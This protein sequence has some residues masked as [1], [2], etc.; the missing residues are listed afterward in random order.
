ME[1]NMT[2]TW[3]YGTSWTNMTTISWTYETSWTNMT[4]MIT[5]WEEYTDTQTNQPEISNASTINGREVFISII[6]W[7]MCLFTAIGNALVIGVFIH[8]RRV[9]NKVSNLYILNLAVADFFVGCVSLPINYFYRQAGV[10]PFGEFGCKFWLLIDFTV[11]FE[12]VWAVVLISYDRYLL[13]TTGLEYDKYQT[14][15][16]FT[17]FASVTWSISFLRY[18]CM[19]VGYDIFNGKSFNYSVTCDNKVFSFLPY[20][21]CDWMVTFFIPVVLTFYFNVKLYADIKRRSRGLPRNW[22]SVTP[23]TARVAPAEDTHS[24]THSSSHTPSQ[25]QP[26][27]SSSHNSHQ[28]HT[29]QLQL[30][31]NQE[32]Q[33]EQNHQ[34]EVTEFNNNHH[35]QQLNV[36]PGQNSVNSPKHVVFSQQ[37]KPNQQQQQNNNSQQ[38]RPSSN[39]VPK[40]T[41]REGTADIRKHRRTAITLGLIVAVSASCWAPYYVYVFVNFA[42]KVEVGYQ[43]LTITY[44]IWWGNSTLNPLLYVA[45][46]PGIRNGIAKI[47]RIKK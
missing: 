6:L 26:H 38:Q 36:P 13:V 10:W 5:S 22:A 20:I 47:L 43:F 7:A 9:R 34:Q 44:Y 29:S 15:K 41:R 23:G 42:F 24:G 35:Q 30:L 39:A 3:A 11:C 14:R 4:T 12:S 18:F 37:S 40:R 31:R 8:D 19:F 21:I 1:L 25:E 2:T 45:T 17:K 16:T 32:K 27:T 46:N 33:Q 28:S